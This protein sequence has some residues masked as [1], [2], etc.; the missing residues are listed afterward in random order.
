VPVERAFGKIVGR[1]L[2]EYQEQYK[3]SDHAT[4]RVARVSQSYWSRVHRGVVD[5]DAADTARVGE[6]LISGLAVSMPDLLRLAIDE[7]QVLK[8]AEVRRLRAADGTAVGAPV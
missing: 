7:V 5:P 2:V 4:A 3:L 1:R 6:R 8:A